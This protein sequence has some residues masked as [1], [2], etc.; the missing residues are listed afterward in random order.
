MP[1][2]ASYQ[3]YQ[4]NVAIIGAG[5]VGLFAVF[6]CGML[7]MKCHVVDALDEI[8]GQC[9]ALYPEKP[10]Y[11]IPGHPEISAG[12][13]ITAL[14]RQA[15]P[16][17]PVY[18]LG[19]TVET[20]EPAT[21]GGSVLGT[22]TGTRI[23]ACAVIIAAGGGAFGPNRPPLPGIESYEGKSI[24]YLVKRR[25]DFAGK[26]VVIAGGG[27]SA[28]DWAL[29]LAEV[30]AHVMVVHRRP[31][32]R[33]APESVARLQEMAEK[34]EIELVVPYQ[35]SGLEGESGVLS[36]VM[37]ATLDGEER[38]L[39][40]DTLLPF[41]GLSSSLGPIADW[42]LEAE[43]GAIPVAADTCQTSRPGI[44]AVGDVAA[45]PGKLKLILT[46]FAE[47]ANAAHA[48]WPLVHPGEE[49]HFQYSTTQG[50]PDA[51]KKN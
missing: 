43:G 2:A 26:R 51:P 20:L 7:G 32:F 34:G 16:F 22:S 17:A 6:Q 47:A 18:H 21:D 44:F 36:A 39:E 37:V 19:Q 1:S 5:P 35:L 31:K 13:L 4:T 45:L 33:A 10:L 23:T 48:S 29:S 41:Y 24:F 9:T 8:G 25:A 27:D 46:G 38:L 50:V 12:D 49:L 40:A 28:V 15:A 30:A 42:G 3:E 14:E 11:D